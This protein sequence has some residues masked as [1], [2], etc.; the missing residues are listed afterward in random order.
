ME[1]RSLRITGA[2]A[3]LRDRNVG[4]LLAAQFSTVTMLYG[5]S[6]AG[7]VL[8]EERTS[9]SIQ[10]GLVIVSSILP[11]FLGSLVSGA[12]V[13]RWGRKRVLM[14]SH[15]GRALLA[16]WFWVGTGT[17]PLGAALATIY[18]VNATGAL[19]S[20]FAT[21]AE[22]ALLPDLVEKQRLV[23]ANALYQL[24]M[25]A[26]EGLG[27][28]LLSPILIKAFGVPAV[29]LAGGGLCLLALAL[30]A[31]LPRDQRLPEPGSRAGSFLPRLAA[32]LKAG[33][34]TISRDRLLRLV[35]VQAT[36]AATLLLVLLSLLP[37]LMSRHLDMPVE[38]APLLIL[39]GGLGFVLGAALLSRWAG[40]FSRPVWIT[41]GLMGLGLSVLLLS[42]AGGGPGRLWLILP[43]ILIMG[44]ALAFTIISARVI[45]QERPPPGMRARVIAAQLA[46]ANAAAVIPLLLGGSLADS[47]GIRPVM[48]ILGLLALGSGLAGWPYA[49][50]TNS[51]GSSR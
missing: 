17:L 39:P 10:I 36:V 6:L 32:D 27:I 26:G 11:A 31:G 7:A 1:V 3:L 8:V 14:A 43:P 48:A 19:L 9:S 42:V 51:E 25:L 37:G 40:R 2:R 15:L 35:T 18:A 49:R 28:I 4:R 38:D 41:V 46:V 29:G 16:I 12:V 13:D 44:V 23:P 34:L 30:V 24:T 50:R 5:L 45:L 21:P 33:W 47:L 22:L 20:Q